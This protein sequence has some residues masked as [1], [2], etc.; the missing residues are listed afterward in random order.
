M[1]VPTKT[2]WAVEPVKDFWSLRGVFR[3]RKI[4]NKTI[5]EVMMLE[6][7]S[8]GTAIAKDYKAKMGKIDE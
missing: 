2:G 5:E 1:I 8:I 4:K 6:K 3:N 7:K